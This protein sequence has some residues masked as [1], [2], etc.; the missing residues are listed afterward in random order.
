MFYALHLDTK[1][2]IVSCEEVSKGSITGSMAAPREVYKAAILS[3]AAFIIIAHN[4]PSGNPNP[5]VDDIRI[6][7]R[8]YKAGEILG[9][10]LSDSV[11]IGNE[12]YYSMKERREI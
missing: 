1:N 4:H 9:I 12:E 7:D 5:S 3:S 2:Q 10:P 6:A 8:L 11:I